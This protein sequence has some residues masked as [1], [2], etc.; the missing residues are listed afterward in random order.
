MRMIFRYMKVYARR[1]ASSMT[2]KLLRTS[3]L[4]EAQRDYVRTS[5]SRGRSRSGILY[6]HVLKNTLVPVLTFLAMTVADLLAGSVVIEQVFAVP[7]LGRLLLTS[8]ELPLL[9]G[10]LG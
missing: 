5:M 6:R 4:D 9:H 2:V 1:I 3:I 7:G 10:G 8:I